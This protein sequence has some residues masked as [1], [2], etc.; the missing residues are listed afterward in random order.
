LYASLGAHTQNNRKTM[1][2]IQPGPLNGS[3]THREI[4][5][6]DSTGRTK[7]HTHVREGI[8]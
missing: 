7:G 6:S 3:H 4:N 2:Q 5:G 1:V 8:P